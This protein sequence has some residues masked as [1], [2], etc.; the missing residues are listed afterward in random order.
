M[1]LVLQAERGGVFEVLEKAY[2][3]LWA[4]DLYG[5]RATE[6]GALFVGQNAIVELVGS[7]PCVATASVT[8]APTC[9]KV[10]PCSQSP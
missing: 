3:K 8:A 2:L 5:S 4:V 9:S 1:W 7:S 10:L 6:G